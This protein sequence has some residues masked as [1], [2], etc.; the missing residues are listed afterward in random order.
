MSEPKFQEHLQLVAQMGAPKWDGVNPIP[1]R[2]HR[3]MMD[4]RQPEHVRGF[5]WVLWRTID[6][7][8]QGRTGPA[9]ERRSYCAHDKRVHKTRGHLDETHM[10]QDLG[11][12]I[13]QAKAVLTRL[14][15]RGLV[16]RDEDGRIIP[17]GNA[18]EPV[19]I[20]SQ[21][22]ADEAGV[23][24]AAESCP[25]SFRAAFLALEEEQR[26]QFVRRYRSMPEPVALHFETLAP[27]PR[28]KFTW[29]YIEKVE[30]REQ[31]EADALAA[32]RAFGRRVVE[33]ELAESGYV[34]PKPPGR[35][36]VNRPLFI[37]LKIRIEPE[38]F[39]V[40]KRN[41]P[42]VQKGKSLS[43]TTKTA[44]VHA[45][46]PYKLLHSSSENYIVSEAHSQVENSAPEQEEGCAFG[47]ASSPSPPTTPLKTGR[48][49]SEEGLNEHLKS[50][51]VELAEETL[52]RKL[53]P[54]DRLYRMYTALP[55]EFAIPRKSV[56]QA[57]QELVESKRK[58]NYPIDNF[59][60]LYDWLHEGLP[61]WI[62]QNW[63]R[64]TFHR[65]EE[66]LSDPAA[67]AAAEREAEILT[68]EAWLKENP[69]HPE[70]MRVLTRLADLLAL[71]EGQA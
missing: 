41:R 68:L 43:N 52:G 24:F 50:S 36:E 70:R 69:E 33:K 37:E 39:A 71:M 56:Y 26:K 62:K 9:K 29:R 58:R 2:S 35:P 11:M 51:I 60:A 65:E 21:E 47:A 5:G 18:P 44:S 4:A 31:L 16:Q 23:Y 48:K 34:E 1:P 55:E 64:V 59:K 61:T 40:E 67:L 49:I 6:R 38:N 32:A 45:P 30:Y 3:W 12:P 19:R 20:L 17:N 27:E 63:K 46:H 10:A 8:P 13:A 57:L 42:F 15:E 7:D 54:L 14:I 22:E 53:N 25:E 66:R 28:A